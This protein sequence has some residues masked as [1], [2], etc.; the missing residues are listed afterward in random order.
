[1]IKGPGATLSLLAVMVVAIVVFRYQQYVVDRVY[2]IEANLACDP[3]LHACFVADCSPADDPECD[4]TPYEK[5]SISAHDAPACL[6][7][8]TCDA[9]TC[10]GRRGCAIIYC[11][12]AALAEGE[13]C[14]E[15]E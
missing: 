13:T 12:E 11:S 3:A 15:R 2:P 6:E 7:A 8:H 9:F 1:M 10:E 5:V 14:S 4:L